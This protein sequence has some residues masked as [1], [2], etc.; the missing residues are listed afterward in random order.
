MPKSE[1]HPSPVPTNDLPARL[2]EA[3]VGEGARALGDLL[4][5]LPG[6]QAI[7]LA[8]K[9]GSGLMATATGRVAAYWNEGR[10]RRVEKTAAEVLRALGEA[11]PAADPEELTGLMLEAAPLVADA[12]TEEK[13]RLLSSILIGGARLFHG[14][15]SRLEASRALRLIGEMPEEAAAVFALLANRWREDPTA[16]APKMEEIPLERGL[17]VAALDHLSH[18]RLILYPSATGIKVVGEGPWLADWV[19]ANGP[20]PAGI[21]LETRSRDS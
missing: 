3:A 16:A 4:L 12:A 2:T 5:L 17:V 20:A 15:A 21:D 7:G 18:A 9:A 10:S 19:T 8:I 6:C 11:G 13:R 14:S 1:K